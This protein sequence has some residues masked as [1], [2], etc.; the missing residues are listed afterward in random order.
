MPPSCVVT[1]RALL[2]VTCFA[3]HLHLDPRYDAGDP[4]AADW[5]HALSGS[6]VHLFPQEASKS[7]FLSSPPSRSLTRR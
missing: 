1:G 3:L 6:L 4:G 7:M 5:R 2:T